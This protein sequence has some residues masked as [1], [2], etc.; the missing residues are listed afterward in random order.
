ML[1]AVYDPALCLQKTLQAADRR[2]FPVENIIFELI[3]GE[4]SPQFRICARSSVNTGNAA[5]AP[6]SMILA[7]DSPA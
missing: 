4:A 2:D 5:F 6:R 7:P 1:N 3:E